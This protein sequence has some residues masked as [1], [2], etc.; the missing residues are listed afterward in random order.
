MRRDCEKKKEKKKEM[1]MLTLCLSDL[2]EWKNSQ[3]RNTN[4]IP[5]KQKKKNRNS[6][7][8][9]ETA[10]CDYQISERKKCV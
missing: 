1:M 3:A 10:L 4:Q 5:P 7:D 9:L 6:I 2:E 8:A